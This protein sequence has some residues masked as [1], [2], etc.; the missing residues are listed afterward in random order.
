MIAAVSN[1]KFSYLISF[2]FD[3]YFSKLINVAVPGTIDERAINTKRVLNPWERNEN[4]TL[5]LNSAKAIGCTLVNIGTQD[6]IEGRV[7]W[8]C[9]IQ[10]KHLLSVW[11][12]VSLFQKRSYLLE[13][14]FN[15][16]FA[17]VVILG[18]STDLNDDISEW[19]LSVLYLCLTIQDEHS[20]HYLNCVRCTSLCYYIFNLYMINQRFIR[21]F[22]KQNETILLGRFIKSWR[23]LC[24]S[25]LK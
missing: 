13:I 19:I 5:C 7:S 14:I 17:C 16:L 25:Q 21:S 8:L 18:A 3:N 23:N 24:D 4:H 20:Y 12:S 10:Y 6:L 22:K 1:E 2:P 11:A 15:F 9:T